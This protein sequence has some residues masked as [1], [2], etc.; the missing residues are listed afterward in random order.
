MTCWGVVSTD[1]TDVATAADGATD[2]P[3][4]CV[5]IWSCAVS[6]KI[7]SWSSSASNALSIN[8]K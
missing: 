8:L 5:P 1:P 4:P 2:M 3:F 7:N 6:V